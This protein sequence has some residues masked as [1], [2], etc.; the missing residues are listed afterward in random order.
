LD[1][2]QAL[3]AIAEAVGLMANESDELT[4]IKKNADSPEVGRQREAPRRD[5]DT[6][7]WPLLLKGYDKLNLRRGQHIP[8]Q[9]GHSPL[10]RPLQDLL[11]YGIINLDKPLGATSADVTAWISGIL[12]VGQVAAIVRPPPDTTGMSIVGLGRASRLMKMGPPIRGMGLSKP[13]L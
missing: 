11:R 3:V 6:S 10:K 8:T 2:L 1:F 4:D 13:D 7:D 5:V 9:C 12:R